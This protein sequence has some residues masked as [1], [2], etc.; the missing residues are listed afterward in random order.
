MQSLRKNLGTSSLFRKWSKDSEY[1]S[2]EARQGIEKGTWRAFKQAGYRRGQQHL[3]PAGD[4]LKRCISH[5][6]QNCPT[7]EQLSTYSYPFLFE[8]Y[9]WDFLNSPDLLAWQVHRS[10]D[11]QRTSSGRKT[12]TLERESPWYGWEL[13]T[14]A[15]GDFLRSQGATDGVPTMVSTAVYPK[16]SVRHTVGS[17]IHQVSFQILFPLL[18]SI[19]LWSLLVSLLGYNL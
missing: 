13:P 9:V 15:A 18:C 6:S 8:S 16:C 5:P 14:K 17:W 2:G 1:S 19:E 10:D 11:S 12:Q 4:L 3:T 7:K